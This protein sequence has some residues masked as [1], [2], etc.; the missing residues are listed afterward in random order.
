MDHFPDTEILSAQLHA[1][2]ITVQR[3]QTTVTQ[4]EL[5]NGILAIERFTEIHELQTTLPRVGRALKR[6]TNIPKG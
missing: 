1:A 4:V 3:L 6:L 5:S 2:L